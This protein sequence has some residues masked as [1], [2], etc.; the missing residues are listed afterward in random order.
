MRE[1][2]HDASKCQ[3]WIGSNRLQDASGIVGSATTTCKAGVYFQV[4]G[5]SHTMLVCKHN[6]FR[7]MMD[8]M[9]HQMQATR[10]QH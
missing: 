9:D 10:D 8:V 3:R 1:M 4:N 7:N 2:R 5:Q 6:E